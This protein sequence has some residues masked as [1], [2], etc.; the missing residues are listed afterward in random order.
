M[1]FI[2]AFS[3]WTTQTGVDCSADEKPPANNYLTVE[4]IAARLSIKPR[5][6]YR[7]SLP[8]GRRFVIKKKNA[9]PPRQ[10]DALLQDISE[11]IHFTEEEAIA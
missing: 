8:S 7:L 5:S 10:I 1:T 11:L 9:D 4:E 6:V 3:H 2:Q